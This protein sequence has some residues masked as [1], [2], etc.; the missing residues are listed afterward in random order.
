M[1]D[2]GRHLYLMMLWEVD[3]HSPYSLRDENVSNVEGND[4]SGENVGNGVILRESDENVILRGSDESDVSWSLIHH[5]CENLTEVSALHW[6]H[7]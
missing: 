1:F 7:E 5:W 2:P 4:E 3:P 6:L